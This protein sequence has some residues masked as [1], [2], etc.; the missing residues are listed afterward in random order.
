MFYIQQKNLKNHT[1][2]NKKDTKFFL[3]KK[4]NTF[5][6]LIGSTYAL[7]PI[8]YELTNTPRGPADKHRI[9][10][11]LFIAEMRLSPHG[12]LYDHLHTALGPLVT[13]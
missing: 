2:I 12:H 7:H 13:K 3:N 8:G 9:Y 4:Q 1:R 10:T 6:L 11:F 5:F